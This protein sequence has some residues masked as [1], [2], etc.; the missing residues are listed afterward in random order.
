MSSI[1]GVV[2]VPEATTYSAT[3]GAVISFS[4]ALAREVA[5]HSIRVN[6]V[7]PSWIDTR[8]NDPIIALMGG[9]EAQA[10]AIRAEI[11]LGRQATPAEIAQVVRFL[12]GPESSFITAQAIIV[13]GGF[14]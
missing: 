7:C 4:K 13:D 9:P 1:T 5:Q 11:P 12:A 10:A 3:K 2:G 8:F 14:S 6:A